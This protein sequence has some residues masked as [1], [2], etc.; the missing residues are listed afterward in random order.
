MCDVCCVRILPSPTV[1]VSMESSVFRSSR[2]PTCFCVPILRKAELLHGT[3][4]KMVM[5]R[6]SMLSKS[7]P[8]A[9]DLGR[10]RSCAI[11]ALVAII[12]VHRRRRLASVGRTS[13]C[14]KRRCHSSGVTSAGSPQLWLDL[15]RQHDASG[16]KRSDDPLPNVADALLALFEGVQSELRRTGQELPKG[17][18]VHAVFVDSDAT[19]ASVAEAGKDLGLPIYMAGATTGRPAIALNL[20]G[21]TVGTLVES[22]GP[23]ANVF[24]ESGSSTCLLAVVLPPDASLWAAALCKSTDGQAL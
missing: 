10:P 14:T 17:Q 20:A 8:V 15:R 24:Q 9:E 5:Q 2:S 18:G 12:L 22:G 4:S 6:V 13:M 21:E 16:Q 3:L 23:G 7:I 19:T 11:T 1:E